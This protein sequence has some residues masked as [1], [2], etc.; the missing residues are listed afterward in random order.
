MG[1]TDES[2]P[3][4]ACTAMAAH[5]RPCVAIIDDDEGFCRS[6][7]RWIHAGAVFS[8]AM[9]RSGEEFLADPNKQRF[10]CLLVDIQLGGMS[11]L[12]LRRR[13]AAEGNRT[14]IVFVTAHD[15]AKAIAEA[16][17]AGCAFLRKTVEGARLAA[18]LRDACK[19]PSDAE[20]SVR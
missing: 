3:L 5:A 4:L 15:D 16:E 20:S 14:P 12:E 1:S 17:G 10:A 13:L 9:Y 6:V 8:A 2:A 7:H 18:A 19:L 11:G